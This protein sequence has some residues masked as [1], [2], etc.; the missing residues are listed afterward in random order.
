[1]MLPG[2]DGC[3][4]PGE[5]GGGA[6]PIVNYANDTLACSYKDV[7][8]IASS[9]FGSHYVPYESDISI[10]NPGDAWFYHKGHVFD[11]AENLFG[12]YLAVVGRGSHF[13]INVPPNR[14]GLIVDEFVTSVTEMGNAVR[15]SFDTDVGH[16]T[17]PVSGKCRC[18]APPPPPLRKIPIDTCR[19]LF[20]SFVP[21]F[22]F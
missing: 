8:T 19:R 4:N 1:M 17:A 9:P 10:Q 21:S 6:Y 15:A 2:P 7:D 13:I 20:H 14:S 22:I 11:S 18:D 12:K 16:L 5:G 3:L